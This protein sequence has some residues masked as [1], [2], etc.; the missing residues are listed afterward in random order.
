MLKEDNRLPVK[1][2]PMPRAI[3]WAVSPH[4]QCLK[5]KENREGGVFER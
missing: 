5:R 4:L 3:V 2:K 1:R